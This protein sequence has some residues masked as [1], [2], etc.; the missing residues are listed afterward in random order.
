MHLKKH[1]FVG[2][3]GI[4]N[5]LFIPIQ[6]FSHWPVN[7]SPIVVGVVTFLISFGCFLIILLDSFKFIKKNVKIKG[8]LLIFLSF[9]GLV[10]SIYFLLDWIYTF[11]TAL[12]G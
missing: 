6:W 7:F 3:L 12:Y 2:I 9:V 8:V 4:L 1:I 11:N 5:L 10:W